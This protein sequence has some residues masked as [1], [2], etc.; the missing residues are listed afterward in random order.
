MLQI[1]Q[2]DQKPIGW[3]FVLRCKQSILKTTGVSYTQCFKKRVNATNIVLPAPR[4]TLNSALSGTV[5]DF[6]PLL[7][8]LSSDSSH[9]L[10]VSRQEQEN[11]KFKNSRHIEERHIKEALRLLYNQTMTSSHSFYEKIIYQG[12]HYSHRMD[13]MLTF[14]EENRAAFLQWPLLT[15][16]G[17]PV[18]LN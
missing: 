4:L 2:S 5:F 7:R 11:N 16:E 10:T 3:I 1:Q 9:W 15:K 18:S 8:L 17:L 13:R 6:W 12:W 14:N